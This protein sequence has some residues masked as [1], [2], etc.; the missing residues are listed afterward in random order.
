MHSRTLTCLSRPAGVSDTGDM[1]SCASEP[2]KSLVLESDRVSGQWITA[3]CALDRRMIK[4]SDK[5]FVVLNELIT[6]LDIFQHKPTYLDRNIYL[7][8]TLSTTVLPLEWCIV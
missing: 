3:A 2:W 4:I 7:C 6:N 1:E 5:T 8:T